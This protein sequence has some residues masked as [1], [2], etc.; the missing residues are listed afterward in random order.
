MQVSLYCSFSDLFSWVNRVEVPWY[1]SI[2]GR[3]LGNKQPPI[4]QLLNT[5][6]FITNIQL[7]WGSSRGVLYSMQSFREPGSFHLVALSTSGSQ[8]QL[9]SAGRWRKGTRIP[10]GSFMWV[11]PESGGDHFGSH[12]IGQNLI[13]WPCLTPREDGK[14]SIAVHTKS[15]EHGYWW[16][17]AASATFF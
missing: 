17:L 12:T 2:L 6:L 15:L 10:C 3:A 7:Q 5:N 8:S 13:T 9:Y 11:M 16:S 1:F 4:S 14:C